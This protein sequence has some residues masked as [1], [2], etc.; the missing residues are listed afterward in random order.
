MPAYGSTGGLCIYRHDLDAK[1]RGIVFID[2]GS[3]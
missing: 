2:R 3:N 1:A